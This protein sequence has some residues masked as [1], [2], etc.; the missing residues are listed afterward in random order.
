M[1]GLE[2]FQAF[3]LQVDDVSASPQ[4]ETFKQVTITTTI[5]MTAKIK[6]Q[7]SSNSRLKPKMGHI[8]ELTMAFCFGDSEWYSFPHSQIRGDPKISNQLFAL[9]DVDVNA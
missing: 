7:P 1:L 8:F 5:L 9:S 6:T 2:V 4:F 3:L